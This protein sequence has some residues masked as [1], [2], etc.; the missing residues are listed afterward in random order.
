MDGSD[1]RDLV[2]LVPD[3]DIEQ[4]VQGLLSRPPSAGM[5]L[6]TIDWIVTRHPAR[7]PGCRTGAVEFLRPF[8]TRF[9]YALA[10]FDR[11]GSGAVCSRSE[12]RTLVE[13]RLFRNGWRNRAKAIAIE[14]ELEAW[15]WNGSAQVAEELGWGRD[16]TGLR[17]HLASKNL[18]PNTALKPPDPKRAAHE[19]MRAAR[20]RNR[21]RRSPAKFN[22]L[23][24][25]IA[26]SVLNNC[27]DPAFRELIATL[28]N[29]FPAT[30]DA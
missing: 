26:V 14:P 20:V 7:D 3:A 15:L 6:Q 11:E 9:R 8:L 24:N 4:A 5:G 12:T 28:R 29:W 16:Y 10:V 23:A 19:A 30:R 17:E 27:Q 22:R 25:Q 18:W 1:V 2:V 13:G 21:A